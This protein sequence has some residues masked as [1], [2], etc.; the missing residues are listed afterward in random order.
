MK[1]FWLILLLAII[2]IASILIFGR[3]S[4]VIKG[5]VSRLK[6]KVFIEPELEPNPHKQEKSDNLSL[7]IKRI[8]ESIA[9]LQTENNNLKREFANLQRQ[10]GELLSVKNDVTDVI[11]RV[12]VITRYLQKQNTQQNSLPEES[13]E[14]RLR[15]S[16]SKD[17]PM[18]LYAKGIDNLNP[19]GFSIYNLK[20]TEENAVFKIV[21]KNSSDGVFGIVDNYDMH[22]VLLAA[23]NPLISVTSEYAAIPLDPNDISTEVTGIVKREGDMLIIVKKQSVRIV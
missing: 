4:E 6:K 11:K 3:N 10:V 17:W 15:T 7:D 23:F 2:V 8:Q 18:T 5:I 13:Q 21:M 12:D 22:Q 14:K 9:K 19:A 20:K 1:I 16:A